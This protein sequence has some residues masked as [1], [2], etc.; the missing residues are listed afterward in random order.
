VEPVT[1]VHTTGVEAYCSR[2]RQKIKA[3][4]GSRLNKISPYFEKFMWREKYGL[5]NADT[6]E[7]MLAVLGEYYS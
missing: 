1:G 7:N 4:H 2:A 3:V 5:A 6:F